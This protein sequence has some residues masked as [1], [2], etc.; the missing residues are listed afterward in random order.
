MTFYYFCH[1]LSGFDSR[2]TD[3]TVIGGN[4]PFLPIFFTVVYLDLY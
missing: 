3:R 2:M 4:M 1:V